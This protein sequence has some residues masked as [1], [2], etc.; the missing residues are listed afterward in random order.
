ML[1]NQYSDLRE[2]E[3]TLFT[4]LAIF[5]A[6]YAAPASSTFNPNGISHNL[7]VCINMVIMAAKQTN[8]N[9]ISLSFCFCIFICTSVLLFRQQ[10]SVIIQCESCTGFETGQQICHGHIC[11]LFSLD[12]QHNISIGHHQSTIS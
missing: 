7:Y 11:S 8:P 4:Y 2:N 3:F 12:V 6:S 10:N 9:H 1:K 5:N